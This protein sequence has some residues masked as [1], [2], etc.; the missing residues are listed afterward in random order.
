[1]RKHY[2]VI[3]IDVN[4]RWPEDGHVY[5]ACL[6]PLERIPEDWDEHYVLILKAFKGDD[7]EHF[8]FDCSEKKFQKIMKILKKGE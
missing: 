1:M 6:H 4:E 7:V 2:E 8:Q 3:T 5:Q